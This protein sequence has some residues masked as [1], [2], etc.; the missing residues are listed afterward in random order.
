MSSDRR[1]PKSCAVW[2]HPPVQLRVIVVSVVSVDAIVSFGLVLVGAVVGF[3]GLV[4]VGAAVVIGMAVVVVASSAVVG[5]MVVVAF[6][7]LDTALS[8]GTIHLW[9]RPQAVRRPDPRRRP[10]RLCAS[11]SGRTGQWSGSSGRIRATPVHCNK[12]SL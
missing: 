8:D 6:G 7:S 9:C 1:R 12:T 5:A 10:C 3:D 4:V 2:H 11:R